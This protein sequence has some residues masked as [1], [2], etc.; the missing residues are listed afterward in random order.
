MQNFIKEIEESKESSEEFY[1]FLI[2]LC[3]RKAAK[4][5]DD[6]S[7]QNA[8]LIIPLSGQIINPVP[9]KIPNGVEKFEERI[10]Q[11]PTK[12]DF[13]EHAERGAIYE[14]ARLGIKLEGATMVCP[15]VACADCSRAIA[16]SG[17]KKIVTHKQRNEA[18]S[19]G[20]DNVTDVVS[21]RWINPITNGMAIL[22]EKEIEIIQLDFKAGIKILINEKIIE[23]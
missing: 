22:A 12:Y 15:W 21:N 4:S 23:I 11:R 20:R 9:N 8:A 7:S 13:I 6:L 17:I 5:S 2:K 19:L 3:Y 1:Q 18:T 14:A 16:L 10:K